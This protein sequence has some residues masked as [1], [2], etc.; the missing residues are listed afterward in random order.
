MIKLN[1][2]HF[3][4]KETRRV[5]LLE[6]YAAFRERIKLEFNSQ[7]GDGDF[8][9]YRFDSSVVNVLQR[10]KVSASNYED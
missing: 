9:I 2:I 4:S 1:V 3:Q 7:L 8:E 10:T 6:T 5:P